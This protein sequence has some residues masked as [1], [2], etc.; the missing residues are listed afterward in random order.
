MAESG[1]EKRRTVPNM[2]PDEIKRL[3]PHASQSTL[4]RNTGDLARLQG[5]E[6]KSNPAQALDNGTQVFKTSPVRV[7]VRIIGV[8][9]KLLDD[10]NFAGGAKALRDRIASQLEVDDGDPRLTW[11]YAQ[12]RTTGTEGTIVT[13]TAQ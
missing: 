7:V 5:A 13:I 4:A 10:D 9:H 1:H 8:R 2:T 11:E 6:R 12:V 3:F